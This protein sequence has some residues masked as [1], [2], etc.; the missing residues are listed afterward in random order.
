MAIE[1]ETT[2]WFKE[3]TPPPKSV[4]LTL[5]SRR[6]LHT[7]LARKQTIEAVLRDKRTN[8]K[9]W[10]DFALPLLGGL[11]R[12]VQTTLCGSSALFFYDWRHYAIVL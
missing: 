8:T 7:N 4:L 10:P 9:A 6:M 11:L 5:F 1:K 3:E 12:N 2:N